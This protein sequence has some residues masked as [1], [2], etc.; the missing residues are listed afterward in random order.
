MSEYIADSAALT[1]T[2]D[3]IRAKT[4]GTDP[5]TWDAAKGFGDAVDAITPGGSAA[6]PAIA[7]A[8][9][10]AAVSIDGDL[11]SLTIDF[12]GLQQYMSATKTYAWQLTMWRATQ[13]ETAAEYAVNSFCINGRVSKG[14]IIDANDCRVTRTPQTALTTPYQLN[15][16][17]FKKSRTV[18]G[19]AVTIVSNT[20]G[21]VWA[22]D[23]IGIFTLLPP[24]TDTYTGDKLTECPDG[25]L[26]VAAT[27]ETESTQSGDIPAE[28]ALSI[29][30]GGV[31]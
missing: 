28:D 20:T 11:G 3:R 31:T 9:F 18:V 14:S 4:G 5:I 15:V 26:T 30:T 7:I 17:D 19:T 12:A 16:T 1:Y 24:Y 21:T 13:A 22:G 8:Q 10:P 25:F 27:T 29:I 23:Y 6:P 2:A